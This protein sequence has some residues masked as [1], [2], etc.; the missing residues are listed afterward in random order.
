MA[1]MRI[2]TN[3]LFEIGTARISELQAKLAQTQNQISTGRR[4]LTP[5]DD[6][7]A[8]AQA[9]L[10]SQS[11]SANEQ[12]ALNRQSAK[13]ALSLEEAT[14]QSV[15]SLMQDVKTLIVSAGNGTLDNTQRAYYATE[16]EGIFSE[17]LG[18]ANSSDGAGNYLF[19]GFQSTVQPFSKTATGAQ[20]GGD[21]GQRMAQITASR[22]I[23]TGDSG[24][25]IFERNKTGNGTFTTAAAAA[26]TGSGIVS[27][28]SI[29]DAA[30]LTG[31]SY[32]VTFTVAADVTT[33]EI[34]DNSTV[35]ATTLP[36]GPFD[37]VS[38][39]AITFDGLQFDVKGEPADGDVFTVDPS[40]NQSVFTTLTNLLAVLKN[41]AGTPAGKAALEN[42]LSTANNN[43]SNAL[44][45]VLTVRASVGIRLKEIENLN[46]QGDDLDLQY[47]QQ[48]EELQGLDYTKAITDLS[49]QKIMLEAAQQAFVQTSNLSLFKFI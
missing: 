6:P 33:Y 14:L 42:G 29:V 41:P 2:S 3:T 48:L 26:N 19:A 22:Q 11:Q 15:T 5:A 7:V 32:A 44:D 20:Y 1:N 9:L 34:V 36:G 12:L 37:Y 40:A 27:S 13:H 31:H 39:Q 18:L 4:I 24:S 35:P 38:G 49:K 43:I 46:I 28:G 25:A 16:L 47:Q 21:Q 30:A 10:V 17:M 23:A 45:N 8:A